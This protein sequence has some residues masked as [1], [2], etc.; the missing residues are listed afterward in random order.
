MGRLKTGDLI[1]ASDHDDPVR[2]VEDVRGPRWSK[3]GVVVRPSDFG[4]SFGEQDVL[5]YSPDEGDLCALADRVERLPERTESV[6]VC[7]LDPRLSGHAVEGIAGRIGT[8]AVHTDLLGDWFR[9]ALRVDATSGAA[10]LPGWE[11]Y[12]NPWPLG[13]RT[14]PY[15]GNPRPCQ[16]HG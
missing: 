16:D 15:D 13:L 7:E 4:V 10:D 2:E 14:C 11:Q 1:L 5:V 6:V 12:R 3:I 9:N 8:E